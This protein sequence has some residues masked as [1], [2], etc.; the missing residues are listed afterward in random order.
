MFNQAYEQKDV[1][2]LTVGQL[3]HNDHY[4][5]PIYQ[6]NYAWG[7][8]QIEQLILDIW[9]V[10]RNNRGDNHY[11][12]GSL[13]VAQR[14]HNHFETIDGQQRHTTLSIL[15]SVM[16]NAFSLPLPGIKGINLHFD[17]RVKSDATLS[18]LFETGRAPD[19]EDAV[20]SS[21]LRA[22]KIMVSFIQKMDIDRS[23]F[24]RY[25]LENV[26]LLRVVVPADTDLNHYFEIMNNRG[27][28]LEKHEILKARLMDKLGNGTGDS[29][30]A[31][32]SII[33]DACANMHRYV[34]LSV[35]HSLRNIWFGNDWNEIPQHFEKLLHPDLNKDQ[36]ETSRTLHDIIFHPKGD[37]TETAHSHHPDEEQPGTFGSVITFPNFLLQVLRLADRD[38]PLDDKRLLE[39]FTANDPDPRQFIMQLLKCR[40]LFDRY[41]IKRENDDEWSLKALTRY[42]KS[43][44]YTSS[45]PQSEK[46]SIR[47]RNIPH[48]VNAI[49]LLSMFHVSFQAQ[50]YKYWLNGALYWL[51]KYTQA[52]RLNV[53]AREYLNYL[54]NMANHFLLDRLSDHASEQNYDFEVLENT[55]TAFPSELDE[56]PLHQGTGVQ[57]YIFNRLDYLLW[58]NLKNKNHFDGVNMQYILKRAEKFT[59]TFRTSV[60]HYWPQNP[61]GNAS[62][63][64]ASQDL[65]KGADNFGNLCLISHSNNSKLSNHSPLA[66]KDHYEKSSYAESLKQ[67][68]MMSYDQWGP[69]AKD[70]IVHHKK[71]MVNVLLY[72]R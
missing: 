5:I 8:E 45:F 23:A 4:T 13:V 19:D 28:Q 65:E 36:R 29:E 12:I 2:A 32:F 22:W 48:N 60:E 62:R 44:S 67:V 43:F 20:E 63:L 17:C 40:M 56:S 47:E 70:N 66:K 71:M 50:I 11:F 6:R 15:L 9:D 52:D 7:Q 68:F 54:E 55:P 72:R 14:G 34:Q 3:F 39:T 18:S 51:N 53:N 46:P 69:A 25:L 27:E 33:W 21:V 64:E 38:T 26:V 49:M 35:H 42:E 30:R 31:A 61:L 24:L 59:F 37:G 58:V 10:A 1:A 57:N 41:I 16:K